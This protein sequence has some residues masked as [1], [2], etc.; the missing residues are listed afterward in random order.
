[1]IDIFKIYTKIELIFFKTNILLYF[2]FKDIIF[3]VF[4]F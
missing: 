2:Y 1:M 4:L 3:F